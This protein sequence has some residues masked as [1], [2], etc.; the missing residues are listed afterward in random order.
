MGRIWNCSSN[1]YQRFSYFTELNMRGLAMTHGRM[2]QSSNKTVSHNW[3]SPEGTANH[4]R[5][6]GHLFW[7]APDGNDGQCTCSCVMSSSL[8]TYYFTYSSSPCYPKLW[9]KSTSKRYIKSILLSTI[10]S[11]PYTKELAL[12]RKRQAAAPA[13]RLT[14]KAG[15]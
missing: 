7:H 3:I 15:Q 11:G 5:A 12:Y 14:Y 10:T 4:K 1:W 8:I 9:K 6:L 13:S 2:R